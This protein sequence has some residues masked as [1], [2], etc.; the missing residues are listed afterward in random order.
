[1]KNKQR[2]KRSAVVSLIEFLRP[3]C[4]W[5][6]PYSL[7]QAFQLFR[8]MV[9]TAAKSRYSD[10][11]RWGAMSPIDLLS[12]SSGIGHSSVAPISSIADLRRRFQLAFFGTHGGN[13]TLRW[14]EENGIQAYGTVTLP[15]RHYVPHAGAKHLGFDSESAIE[16]ALN[17]FF[18][19]AP[20][21]RLAAQLNSFHAGAKVV[22]DVTIGVSA[23]GFN[24][25]LRYGFTAPKSGKLDSEWTYSLAKTI[26][27]ESFVE[28]FARA[29][30]RLEELRTVKGVVR[31]DE[32][33]MAA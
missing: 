20:G 19:K 11:M 24:F 22:Q 14:R 6:H 17:K 18:E 27:D 23:R 26:G 7:E 5:P 12:D 32:E 16:T 33:L 15:Y 2:A 28:T 1:M 10:Q 8:W 29:I 4:Y 25:N 13:G 30:A 3:D 31:D 9:A 21:M